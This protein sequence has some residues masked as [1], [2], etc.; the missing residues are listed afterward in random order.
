MGQ[1]NSASGLFTENY[2]VNAVR[3]WMGDAEVMRLT[4]EGRLGVGTSTPASELHVA[5]TVTVAGVDRPEPPPAGH[6]AL[7][8]DPAD[9]L[10][11]TMNSQGEV[12]LLSTP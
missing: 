4:R 11:K 1:R 2:N 9:N 8:V 6:V 3:W 7:Y 10:L 12:S 5:G